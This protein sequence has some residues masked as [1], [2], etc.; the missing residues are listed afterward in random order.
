MSMA[1]PAASATTVSMAG[2]EARHRS[3]E[4][5]TTVGFGVDPRHGRCTRRPDSAHAIRDAPAPSPRVVTRKRDRKP[6]RGLVDHGHQH[7]RRRASGY[8]T[9]RARAAMRAP[10]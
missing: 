4:P 8:G 6:R 7:R 3:V 10:P 2:R 9:P 1:L 5:S